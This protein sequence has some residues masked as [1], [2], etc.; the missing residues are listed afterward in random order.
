[1]LVNELEVLKAKGSF[2]ILGRFLF[3]LKT[4]TGSIADVAESK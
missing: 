4:W 1:M 3:R 2:L